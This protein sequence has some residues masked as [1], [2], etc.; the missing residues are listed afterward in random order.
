M[1]RAALQLLIA[2]A[3]LGFMSGCYEGPAPALLSDQTTEAAMA[4]AQSYHTQADI[5]VENNDLQS[6]ANAMTELIEAL[7]RTSKRQDEVADLV[8]DASGRL[9]RIL[10][11]EGK[12]DEAL[13]AV[14]SG[15]ERGGERSKT[16]L[17]AGYL[18]QSRGDILRQ[19]GDD[20]GAVESHR[21]AIVI[22]KRLLDQ[23]PSQKP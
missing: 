9:S 23:K 10:S 7:E 5:A 4:M 17:F 11:E 19:Q 2:L 22:F 14:E 13:E 1:T 16:S 20:R 21:A 12:L 18:W 15:L 3:S 8:M 6:A